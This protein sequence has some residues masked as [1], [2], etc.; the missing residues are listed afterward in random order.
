MAALIPNTIMHGLLGY[1]FSCP[2][3]IGGGQCAD[4]QNNSVT[5]DEEL[6]VRY[7]QCA[8]LTPMMQFSAAPWRVLSRENADLCRR[9]A[10]I[11]SRLPCPGWGY[12]E[13]PFIGPAEGIGRFITAAGGNFFNLQVLPEQHLGIGQTGNF[14]KGRKILPRGFFEELRKIGLRK[15]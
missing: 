14:Q 12:P 15:S 1:P 11:R 9:A 10:D 6:F 13:M 8:A 4:F 2:D 5:L 7:A 3:M